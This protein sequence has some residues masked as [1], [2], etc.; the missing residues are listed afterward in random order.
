VNGA[1]P[2]RGWPVI[3]E[4]RAG[5]GTFPKNALVT[6]KDYLVRV[7]GN[8]CFFTGILVPDEEMVIPVIFLNDMHQA[9][10][11]AAFT[12]LGAFKWHSYQPDLLMDIVLIYLNFTGTSDT[13]LGKRCALEK[14][15]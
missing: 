10:M 7:N 12:A 13:R 6:K 15:I 4:K 8:R 3:P 9:Q 5:L 14:R 1:V 11:A 2:F